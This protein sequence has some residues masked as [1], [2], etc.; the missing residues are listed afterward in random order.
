M[1]GLTY[2]MHHK[3]R[4]PGMEVEGATRMFGRSI[5]KNKMRYSE[6][7]SDGDSKTFPAI[8]EIHLKEDVFPRIEVVKKECVGHVQKRVGNRLRKLK[9]RI[10]G[11][12][13]KG[14]LTE[15]INWQN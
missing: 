4:L 5:S 3:G 15:S 14:K 8:E 6:L 9:K 11:L 12:G 13:G 1:E 2:T 10:R 7:F